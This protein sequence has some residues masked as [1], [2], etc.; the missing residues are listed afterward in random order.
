[1][2]SSRAQHT[3][4]RTSG[5]LSSTHSD[6]VRSGDLSPSEGALILLRLLVAVTLVMLGA[7]HVADSSA[8]SERLASV[9]VPEPTFFAIFT[10]VALIAAGLRTFT[11]KRIHD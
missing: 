2:A 7:A 5:S 3:S 8:L 11:G 6:V 4:N 10:G 9:G 1:M